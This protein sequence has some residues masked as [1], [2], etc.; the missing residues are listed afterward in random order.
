MLK[1][2]IEF[3]QASTAYFWSPAKLNRLFIGGLENGILLGISETAY[4]QG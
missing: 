1:L 2:K 3:G 4:F